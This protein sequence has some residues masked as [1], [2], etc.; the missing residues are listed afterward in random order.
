M[1]GTQ[2]SKH[3]AGLYDNMK[4]SLRK[5]EGQNLLKEYSPWLD[6]FQA[7]DYTQTIEVPGMVISLSSTHTVQCTSVACVDWDE[8]VK[9]YILPSLVDT[10]YYDYVVI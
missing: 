6:S 10:V 3:V 5:Q 7:S 8:L 1:Q 9:A 2:F 4:Q